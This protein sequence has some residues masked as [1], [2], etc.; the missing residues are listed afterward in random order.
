[1]ILAQ[2]WSWFPHHHRHNHNHNQSNS[3]RRKPNQVNKPFH[4]HRCIHNK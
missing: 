2:V 3:S 1:M 4:I